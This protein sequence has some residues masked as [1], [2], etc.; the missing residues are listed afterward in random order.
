MMGGD[1]TVAS[2]DCKGSTFYLRIDIKKGSVSD[3][4]EKIPTRRVIGFAPRQEIPRV[5][6]AEDME[7]SRS[8]L[9][10][11]LKMVGFD[12]QEAVNGKQAVEIS[13]KWKP[14]FIW[15]DIRM[16]VMGGLEATQSIKNTAAGQST[17]VAA[18]TAHALEE[19]KEQIL[20][21]GCDD[22]VRKPFRLH[23]IF[24]VMGKHLGLKY[25]YEDSQD[26]DVQGESEGKIQ[27]EQLAALPYLGVDRADKTDR[28]AHGTRIGSRR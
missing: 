12:V 14:D 25:M 28:C 20:S 22:F 7:A 5:L 11:T 10:K 26:E 24:E 27:L 17:I 9:V 21:A 18:L 1:I 2:K 8:L 6:V 13:Q 16:P 23:E 19:E 15:M 4:E 3:I